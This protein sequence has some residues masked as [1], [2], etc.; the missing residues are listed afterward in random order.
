MATAVRPLGTRPELASFTVPMRHQN[1]VVFGGS[2]FIGGHVVAR[3]VDAGRRVTVVTRRREHAQSL[4][5]LPTVDVVEANLEDG[6]RLE[7]ILRGQDA[8]INLI[9]ILHSRRG[10]PYGP[11][12]A[13]LHV[14][15]PSH[16]MER[17]RAAGVARVLHM[18][19]LGAAAD[20]PS[21][22]LRSKADG[23]RAVTRATGVH[24]TVMRP[25]VVFGADDHFMNL[26]ATLAR[27]SPVLPLACASARFQPV[28]VGDVGQAFV[29]ALDD[30]G[31]YGRTYELAGPRIYTLAEIVR[32]AAAASGHRRP[33]LALPRALARIQAWTFEHLPGPTLISRDNLDSM[34]VDSIASG[35]LPGLEALASSG[36]PIRPT[37][38]E[39]VAVEQL[40]GDNPR[41]HLYLYRA[42]AHR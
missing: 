27:W 42:R 41:A 40:G 11:D 23:E 24:W 5:L 26:F 14:E 8:V 7:R 28:W 25:S 9:G 39:A 38:L 34:Q 3:L 37:S 36:R 18:S 20:A 6:P 33:I 32:I 22:Y 12:F 35:A 2:G 4:I 10:K 31:S 15:W 16:L 30:P 21:M 29:A 19:A 17:V 1:V 13:R